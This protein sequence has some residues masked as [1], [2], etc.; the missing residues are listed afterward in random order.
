MGPDLPFPEHGLD[1]LEAVLLVPHRPPVLD[2]RALP[3][4]LVSQLL[5]EVLAHFGTLRLVLIVL[6]II[7]RK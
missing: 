4:Y 3:R 2:G 6:L 1:L 7:P 5:E